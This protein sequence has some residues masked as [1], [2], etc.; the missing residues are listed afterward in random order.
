MAKIGSAATIKKSGPRKKT[1]QGC[2]KYTKRPHN[3]RTKGYKKP[4]RGQG[5]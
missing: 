5:R 3:R 4:Y 1:R 2:G